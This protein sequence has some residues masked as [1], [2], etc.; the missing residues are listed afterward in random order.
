MTGDKN[1]SVSLEILRLEI[2]RVL[3]RHSYFCSVNSISNLPMYTEV[4]EFEQ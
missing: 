4:K 1:I 2:A 3:M